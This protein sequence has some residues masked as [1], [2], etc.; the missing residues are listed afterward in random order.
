MPTVEFKL[1]DGTIKNVE[2]DS[3]PTNDDIEEVSK[4]LNSFQ[5][6][7]Q[8]SNI[9]QNNTSSKEPQKLPLV[10]VP[11]PEE[12]TSPTVLQG[13]VKMYN[14]SPNPVRNALRQAG[15]NTARFLLPKKAENWFLGSKEDEEYLKSHNDANTMSFEDARTLYDQGILSKEEFVNAIQERA[16]L[17]NLQ[18]DAEYRDVRNKN[19]GKGIVD[20]G[21]A[22]IPIGGG[23]KI[24]LKGAD[25]LKPFLGKKIAT[26]VANGAVTGAKAGIIHG[27]ATGIVDEDVNPLVS[28][29]QEGLGGTLFG[30]AL[31]YG[32]EKI[33]QGINARKL[34]NL[35]NRKDLRKAETN[36]YKDYI[37]QTSVKRKDLGDIDF[38]QAGLETVSK[39][40]EAG[41]NFATL[42]KDI[43]NAV[44]KN[45]ELPDHPR[46]DGIVKFHRLEKDGQDFLIGETAEGKKYY[47]SKINDELETRPSGGGTNPSNN[48]ITDNAE[49]F[50]PNI[51][52]SEDLKNITVGTDLNKAGTTRVTGD[53][54]YSKLP[55]SADLPKDVSKLANA[56][57]NA[58]EYEVLHNNDLMSQAQKEIIENPDELTN[59]TNKALSKDSNFTALDFE[60]SRQILSNLLNEG[61]TEQAVQLLENVSQKASKAGQAVQALSLWSKTTKE[62]AL[63]YAQKLLDKYNNG[64]KGKLKKNLTKE[65]INSIG[66]K[67]DNLQKLQKTN[68]N[69]T[70]RQIEVETAKALKEVYKVVPKTFW[71]KVDSI[72]YMNMLLSFKSRVKDFILTGV[73]AAD[74]AIDE[75][76]ASGIDWTRNKIT[77][78][79]RA[80]TGKIRPITYLKGLT[81]GIQEGYEDVKLGINT[82]RSGDMGRYGLPMTPTFEHIPMS[83]S[84]GLFNKIKTGWNNTLAGS[85]KLLRY[86]LNVPDRM[87]YEARY[88]TSLADQMEAAGVKK[89][90]EEMLK[91][92]DEEAKRAVF[93]ENRPITDLMTNFRNGMDDM[94]SNFEKNYNLPNGFLPRP[95]KALIPFVKTPTNI[96]AQGGEGIY[97][98]PSGLLAM[99]TAQTPQQMRT[100]ELLTARG[101]KG[102]GEIALGAG[103]GKNAYDNF[104]TNINNGNYQENEIS[105]LKPQSIAYGDKAFSLA[106]YPQAMP[107]V[108]GVGLGQNGLSGAFL[109]S[110]NAA[111]DMPALKAIGELNNIGNNAL[112]YG[113]S[114]N[115]QK[116]AKE[117]LNDTARSIGTNYLTTLIPMGGFLGELRNDIDPY[118]R[119]LFTE[120]TPEYIK[121][122]ILNRIPFA[123]QTL[124]QKYNAIG[125]PVM[126]NNIQDP[127]LRGVSEA[128]D[129]GIRNR[130]RNA[131]YDAYKKLGEDVQDTDIQGKTNVPITKSKRSVQ[132]NGEKYPLNNKQYSNYQREY[133]KIQT[134]LRNDFMQNPEFEQ[135]SDEEKVKEISVLRQSVEEAVKIRQLGHEPT[136]KLKKYTEYILENYDNLLEEE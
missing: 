125:E 8:S 106:S 33:V 38:T 13:Q 4:H 63:K 126:T 19:I 10:Q 85:E 132:V 77:K 133:G 89:P 92:A 57:E 83:E 74:S 87:F 104:Y 129:L 82:S 59:I 35:T 27:G 23:G 64:A 105:G 117:I 128:I 46:N 84:K 52:K 61:K 121:N 60:K 18:A 62:G 43:K 15:R 25:L 98:I 102:A 36:Y 135:L 3:T 71:D 6:Q 2:F 45:E 26:G 37:Q 29:A 93:Q 115:P 136:K 21:T 20:I 73:H 119:E 112:N 47:M 78:N 96:I 54:K 95:G 109:A 116:A 124:P 12:N 69:L 28:A 67:F 72:R 17:T 41:R 108:S 7:S 103:L 49:N 14:K 81:K 9:A 1:Q 40:P 110:K 44:Y 66:E 22:F 114:D 24:A 56:P 76:I 39:Q 88:A 130:K 134:V 101:I 68:P 111:L 94:V 50:N 30:G 70:D 97:G 120:N 113:Y 53:L 65:Q 34:K 99:K 31:G 122:R 131:T 55:Q 58:A 32:G 86:S 5:N 48:I 90:T 16:K 11:M 79:G 127:L 75:T 80:I 123:S 42:K 51:T 100:A 118:S 91:L 107:F